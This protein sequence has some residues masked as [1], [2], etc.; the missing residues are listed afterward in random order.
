[1]TQNVKVI[2]DTPLYQ[3][4]QIVYG[5]LGMIGWERVGT[6]GRQVE[7]CARSGNLPQAADWVIPERLDVVNSLSCSGG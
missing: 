4:R 7:R 6:S 3:K 2:V 5:Q 1:M